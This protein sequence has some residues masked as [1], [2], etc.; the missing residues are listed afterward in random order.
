MRDVSRI[1]EHHEQ[2]RRTRVWDR[3]WQALSLIFG[4]LLVATDAEDRPNRRRSL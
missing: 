2:T 1:A 4:T 3:R